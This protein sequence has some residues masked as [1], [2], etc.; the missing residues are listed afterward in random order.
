[1]ENKELLRKE[2]NTKSLKTL[3]ST[4]CP[5]HRGKEIQNR[6]GSKPG[7]AKNKKCVPSLG[8]ENKVRRWC[9]LVLGSG[10][11]ETKAKAGAMER[12]DLL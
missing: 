6:E 7:I 3:Q 2:E 1:M 5:P 9:S 4:L 8:L 12:G 10:D 11:A